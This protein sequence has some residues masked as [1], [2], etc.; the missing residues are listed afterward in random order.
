MKSIVYGFYLCN[1]IQAVK[2]L[3]SISRNNQT[4]I[5]NIPVKLFL[6]ENEYIYEQTNYHMVC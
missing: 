1:K 5:L 3:A 2:L 4:K 6:P